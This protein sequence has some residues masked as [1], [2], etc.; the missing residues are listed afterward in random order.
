MQNSTGV[1]RRRLIKHA[2]RFFL[3]VVLPYILLQLGLNFLHPEA[4]VIDQ[5]FERIRNETGLKIEYDHLR[6]TRTFGIEF[7]H[8]TVTQTG[9]V[10]IEVHGQKIQLP[11]IRILTADTFFVRSCFSSLFRL[12]AGLFF[13]A[14]FYSGSAEGVFD[15]PFSGRGGS[16]ID[17]AWQDVDLAALAKEHADLPISSG[18]LSGDV[19]LE[20]NPELGYSGFKGPVHIALRDTTFKMPQKTGDMLNFHDVR[21]IDADIRAE[22]DVIH[23]ESVTVKGTNGTM[24]ITGL[25]QPNPIPD[26]T[27]LDLSIKIFAHKTDEEPNENQYLP[28]TIKGSVSRPTVEFLGISL[29]KDGELKSPF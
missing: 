27:Y 15:T 12:R 13:K 4:R 9:Q 10:G 25:I 22:Q 5:T 3:F 17:V 20:M 1:N 21:A 6:F 8:L 11:E 2:R 19:D 18:R 26:N 28:V 14:N 29:Y 24:R 7:E 16:A 23:V